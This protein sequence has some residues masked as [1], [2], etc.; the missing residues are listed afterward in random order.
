MPKDRRMKKVR[1]DESL[2]EQIDYYDIF[3]PEI[4]SRQAKIHYLV[5]IGLV[6]LPLKFE[7]EAKQRNGEGNPVDIRTQ[8]IKEMAVERLIQQASE[9]K[10]PRSELAR[11]VNRSLCE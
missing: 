3:P 7:D 1:I 10:I 5:R 11:L 4:W 9:T 6:V 8:I 2:L